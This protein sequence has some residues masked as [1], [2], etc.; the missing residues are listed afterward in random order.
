MTH[1]VIHLSDVLQGLIQGQQ[2]RSPVRRQ[3]AYLQW[4]DGTGQAIKTQR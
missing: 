4:E 3:S 1:N 2:R